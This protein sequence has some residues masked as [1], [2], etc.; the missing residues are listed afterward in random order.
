MRRLIRPFAVLAPLALVPAL[1]ARRPVVALLAMVSGFAV[2]G[3]MP[4]L[5]G[6]FVLALP[7]GFRARAFGVMRAAC[8]SARAARC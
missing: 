1:F 4:T 5:N 2:A 7:H 8:R 3:L 6:M